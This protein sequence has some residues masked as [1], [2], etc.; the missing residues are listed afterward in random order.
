MKKVRRMLVYSGAT[1]ILLVGLALFFPTW[2]PKIEGKN[3]ISILEQVEIN[4]TGHELLIR[5][6]DKSNP[7]VIF[8][9]GGPAVSEIPYATKY[10]DLLEKDFTVV[11][12]DQRA[13]GKSYHFGEDYS[14]L[15]TDLL[16]E[17]LLILTDYISAR[18]NQEKVI[19]VGHS[20]GTYIGIQAAQQAPDK[21]EAY[22][23]IGQVSN[24]VDSEWDSMNYVIDQAKQSGNT[25]DVQYLQGLTE[26]VRNGTALV[27]RQYVHKYGG[28][29]RLIDAEADMEQGLWFGPE[30][31]LLDRIRYNRGAAY[32]QGILIR[33]ALAEPLPTIVTKLEIPVYFIMG[34][35]DYMTS[36]KSAKAYFDQIEA[37]SKEFITYEQSAHYP[38]FE[39]KETFSKWMVDSFVQQ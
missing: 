2:T 25:T 31:N 20:S 34:Q 13:S 12:Y 23:G 7:V 30:Y 9:H 18:L 8:V 15:S 21:Y 24:I 22:I 26:Q 28:A 6:Q 32:S 3:S 5:G 17:D 36:A 39:E 29:A 10:Q 19:L 35:Y 27:P 11:R 14:N 38:Q 16:V 37:S 1:I 4:G 33:Q